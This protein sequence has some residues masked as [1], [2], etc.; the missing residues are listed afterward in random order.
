VQGTN[1]V[2]NRAGAFALWP[3]TKN[4]LNR[5]L[6]VA[7]LTCL[8]VPVISFT[9]TRLSDDLA[10]SIAGPDACDPR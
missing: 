4:S 10:A 6:L 5:R 8:T 7:V 9:L 2:V 1:S 3:G